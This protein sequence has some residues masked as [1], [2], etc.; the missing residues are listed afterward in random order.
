MSGYE[1]NEKDI[2]G[3]LKYLELF[4]PENANHGF[5]EE[6]LRYVKVASR[7]MALTDPDALDAL[8]NDFQRSKQ[9]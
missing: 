2:Q 9:E 4:H 7:R 3:V 8:Y 6:L 1:V 5:A